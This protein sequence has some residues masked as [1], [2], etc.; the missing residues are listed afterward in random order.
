MC[1]VFIDKIQLLNVTYFSTL[2]MVFQITQ[3]NTLNLVLPWITSAMDK[4][5][6]IELF[7]P[8][9]TPPPFSFKGLCTF[10]IFPHN[11]NVIITIHILQGAQNVQGFKV[12]HSV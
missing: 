7:F 8:I 12:R 6:Q 5:K 3:G 11:Y 9:V 2:Y 1:W 4:T 10:I